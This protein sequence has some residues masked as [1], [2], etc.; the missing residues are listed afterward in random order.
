MIGGEGEM[1]PK[2]RIAYSKPTKRFVAKRV[3]KAKDYSYLKV[4]LNK[5]IERA[6]KHNKVSDKKRKKRKL[7]T[8]IA[9]RERPARADT[10]ERCTKYSRLK[11][12]R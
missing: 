8:T 4:I 5:V 7:P 10:I 3:K 1:I 9:P 6:G 11:L 2:F 12:Q